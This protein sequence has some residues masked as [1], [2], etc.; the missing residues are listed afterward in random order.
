MQKKYPPGQWLLTCVKVNSKPFSL[1]ITSPEGLLLF[2]V[3]PK[4][5]AIFRMMKPVQILLCRSAYLHSDGKLYIA[6]WWEGIWS[7]N[8]VPMRLGTTIFNG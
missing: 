1:W 7:F 4:D 5:T 8:T 3:V 2:D 6:T